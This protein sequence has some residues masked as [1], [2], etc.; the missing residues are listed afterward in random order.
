MNKSDLEK[1][2]ELIDCEIVFD[3][4]Y[5]NVQDIIKFKEKINI[6]LESK[7]I[8]NKD[9]SIAA[10]YLIY[11]VSRNLKIYLS[12]LQKINIAQANH[13]ISPQIKVFSLDVTE[14]SLA[15][16]R[17][18]FNSMNRTQ[19]SLLSLCINPKQMS[20]TWFYSYISKILAA[21]ILEEYSGPIFLQTGSIYFDPLIFSNHRDNLLENLKKTIQ[22]AIRSG[23]YNLD[24]DASQLIEQD[25]SVT[26]E[27]MLMN[28]KMVAMATN[29][30]IRNYQPNGIVV[31]ISGKIGKGREGFIQNDELKDYLKRLM[32]EGSRLRFSTAG[33]DISK[34]VVDYESE[35]N[36]PSDKVNQLN[37]IAQREFGLGGIVID[38]QEM[39]KISQIKQLMKYEVCEIKAKLVD[40]LQNEKTYKELFQI[41][42]INNT[43]EISNKYAMKIDQFPKIN[44]Y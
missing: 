19:T 12:S 14:D 26:S 42:N 8:E 11:S 2:G 22:I 32:K 20:Q 36:T 41:C 25:K 13:E 40:D 29:L 23:I 10:F 3:K 6:L 35:N 27:I 17:L 34:I 18:I 4:G 7:I 39:K 9:L 1:L 43:I 28:L 37:M 24:L 30:W 16:L 38:L 21:A 5:V 33:D 31:S 15:R 44:E